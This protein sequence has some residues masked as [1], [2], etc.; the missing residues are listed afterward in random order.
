MGYP[1][2]ATRQVLMAK[3]LTAAAQ[4]GFLDRNILPFQK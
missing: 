4:N 1:I 3:S 2:H